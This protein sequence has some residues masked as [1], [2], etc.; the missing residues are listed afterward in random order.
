MKPTSPP[1]STL[2][3]RLRSG[4]AAAGLAALFALLA[5]WKA[6]GL[7]SDNFRVQEEWSSR[8]Y[9]VACVQDLLA[10]CALAALWLF[11]LA[12]RPKLGHLALIGLSFALLAAQMVDAR[13]KVRFLHPL[14]VD[15]IA[16]SLREID[17]LGPDFT[18][19]TG[20][21]YWRSA[22]ASLVVLAGAFSLP[23]WPW[24]GRFAGGLG[25]G[26]ARLR[27]PL[28]GAVAV[29]LVAVA[30]SPALPY[31]LHRN[32]AVAT[33]LRIDRRPEGVRDHASR[34]SDQPL[35]L[36]TREDF[37][38]VRDPSIALA[39]GWNV[40]LY[41]LESTALEQTSLGSRGADTTPFLRELVE[42]GGVCVPCYAQVAN[43]AKATFGLYSGLYASTSMEVLECGIERTPGLARTLK[44][45]GYASWFVSPQTLY[46]QGQRTMFRQMAFDEVV[47][48]LDL[49]EIAA[50]RNVPFVEQ[51]PAIN[52]DRLMMLWDHAVLPQR[53]PF[54]LSYYTQS[55]HFGYRYPGFTPGPDEER[56]A[57]A[58]RYADQVLREIVELHQRLGVHER[59][60]YVITADH[61]EDFRGG[62]FAPRN[63]SLAEN[64]HRTP[65]VIYAPGVDLHRFALPVARQVDVV[66]TILDLL[67]LPLEGLPL[68]G[69]SLF[70]GRGESPIFLGSYGTE[71]VFGLIE[72]GRK[73]GLDVRS[74]TLRTVDLRA[75]PSG[76]SWSAADVA[77]HADIVRR[78]EEFDT[79]N[80]ACLRDLAA[81]G[82]ADALRR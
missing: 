20:G 47:G 45:Q 4:S 27:W 41:V 79:Y 58:L 64:G 30:A 29:L 61:G 78:L 11:A 65:L 52:D 6:Y 81:A 71:R 48:F 44:E 53:Q 72:A 10:W 70:D 7:V 69:R 14:S 55:T 42:R 40:V 3:P 37:G 50:A 66:P 19:F 39:K 82:G 56:H 62:A 21:G 8:V 46:Y 17:T 36:A 34:R 76:L 54:F 43:S 23:W 13:M 28:A 1:E 73:W 80:E 5:F 9:L 77:Q 26:A 22:C 24:V 35:R 16:F 49:R 32:F 74:R 57:R 12:R 59:T 25:A 67:G 15:W 75:D 63:S 2:A 31:G 68:Q 38:C 18:L 33:L 60:L 51:G